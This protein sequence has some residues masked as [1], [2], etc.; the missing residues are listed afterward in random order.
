MKNKYNIINKKI[1]NKG[2]IYM[3]KERAKNY[4]KNASIFF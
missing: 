2:I 4:K 3:S 1:E